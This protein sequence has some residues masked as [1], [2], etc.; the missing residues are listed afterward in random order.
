MLINMNSVPAPNL[1]GKPLES[2]VKR[3]LVEESHSDTSCYLLVMDKYNLGYDALRKYF[4][5]VKRDL[6]T[7]ELGGRP[8][9]LDKE[10]ELVALNFMHEN[11]GFDKQDIHHIVRTEMLETLNRRYPKGIPP[12]V[13]KRIAKSSVRRWASVL[14]LKHNET[15][16]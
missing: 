10:S 7:F 12:N 4:K 9:K 14:I 1:R 11:L 8:P 13:S 16:L 5:R 15:A 2:A 3:K 6:P